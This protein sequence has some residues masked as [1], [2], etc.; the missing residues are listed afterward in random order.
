[1]VWNETVF[2]Y[3]LVEENSILLL[4][5]AKFVF[6]SCRMRI[7]S[8]TPTCQ[9]PHVLN[10]RNI[11]RINRPRKKFIC[12]AEQKSQT[13]FATCRSALSCWKKILPGVPWRKGTTSKFNTSR[14]Y[15]LLLILPSIRSKLDSPWYVIPSQ[16]I[17]QGFRLL[18][19]SIM[20]SV[21]Q[22]WL[23]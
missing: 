10:K 15:P 11:R 18:C 19:R 2:E 8:E 1:M 12:W 23:A 21:R 22:H 3:L 17:T 20:H 7:T 5:A 6:W 9:I 13:V 16:T 14:T 4:C